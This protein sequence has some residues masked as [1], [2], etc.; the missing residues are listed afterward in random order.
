MKGERKT[1]LLRMPEDLQLLATMAAHDMGITLTAFITLAVREKVRSEYI[2]GVVN[3][4]SESI[5]ETVP[6]TG[7]SGK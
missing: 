3:G 6:E 2:G 1:F 4:K 7:T 5:G